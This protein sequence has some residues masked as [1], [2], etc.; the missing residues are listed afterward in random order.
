MKKKELIAD[1]HTEILKLHIKSIGAHCEALGMN[2]ENMLSAINNWTPPYGNQAYA[3]VLQKWGLVN[4]DGD[5][6]I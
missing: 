2:A 3:E 5:P 6:I 4:K 1:P